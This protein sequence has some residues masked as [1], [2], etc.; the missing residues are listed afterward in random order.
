[1]KG[2]ILAGGKGTRLRPLTL[3]TSKQLLPVY[4]KP[5]IYYPL[6]TLL[7]AGIDEILIIS[8]KENL[9]RIKSL[10]ENDDR[11]INSKFSISYAEQAEPKGI[12]EALIIGREFIGD[13][14]VCLILGD[15]IFY[16][17]GF[18]HGIL[19]KA[20][21]NAEQ[22]IVTL[23]GKEVA[24]MERFGLW[25]GNSRITPRIVEKPDKECISPN[26]LALLGMY[27][28]PNN[29]LKHITE[30]NPSWRGELEITD[31]N[32][33]LNTIYPNRVNVT[34]LG[35]GFTWF[36]AGTFNSLNDAC[37]FIRIM[38]ENTGFEI[39]NPY[40]LS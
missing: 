34:N 25:Q 16:G 15:N 20:V 4:D 18:T 32:N 38:Q 36:D 35:K 22:G 37:N 19:Q 39:C 29:V 12:L 23:F 26:S 14:D 33:L 13:D 3:S 11:Y 30:I 5:M 21:S 8:D 28:Y 40:N 7:L 31:F 17:P 6:S 9:P 24:E 10:F 27:M 1:M 2:I